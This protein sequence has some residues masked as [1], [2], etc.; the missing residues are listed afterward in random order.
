MAPF[1]EEFFVHK[2]RGAAN[3]LTLGP[4]PDPP[5]PPGGGGQPANANLFWSEWA[6]APSTGCSQANNTDNGAWDLFV[7]PGGEGVCDANNTLTVRNDVF[8]PGGSGKSLRKTH[9]PGVVGDGGGGETI[10]YKTISLGTNH[11][12]YTRMYFSG[13]MFFGPIHK[14]IIMGAGVAQDLYMEFGSYYTYP[15][16]VGPD[17]S[18]GRIRVY[19]TS[20]D[21][22]YRTINLQF[23]S[24][25]WY[26]IEWHVNT[27]T[28]LFEMKVDGVLMH[29]AQEGFNTDLG[30]SMTR[31][32]TGPYSYFKWS[33]YTNG[34]GDSAMQAA[35]PFYQSMGGCGIG[36]IDWIRGT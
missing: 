28:G 35:M 23:S 27:A 13:P 1:S 15:G 12:G 6:N 9:V 10:V 21:T 2:H 22:Y 17:T 7:T 26:E 3:H 20:E 33:T 11:Y 19:F 31:S 32:F 29:W 14:W 5:P 4:T 16:N 8:W 36:N 30:T 18:H 34:S 24:D 25:T